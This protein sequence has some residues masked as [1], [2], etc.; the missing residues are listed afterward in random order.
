MAL[1]NIKTTVLEDSARG[2]AVLVGVALKGNREQLS[3]AE[4]SIDELEGLLETA[5]GTVV[6]KVIQNIESRNASTLIGSGKV[7]EISELCKNHEVKLVVFD[8]E[9]T[10]VQIRNLEDG[11][12]EDVMVIDRTMLILDIFALHATTAEGKLQVEMA[13]L[14]YSSP[15]LIGKGAQLSR[16][17]GGIGTRGPGESQLETDRRYIKRREQLLREQLEKMA[18]TRATMRQSRE[19]S[20]LPRVSIVGYTNAGKS[21]LLNALTHAG[22][23]AEDKLF[24]TLDPTT[25]KY[26]LPDGETIL[27]TDTVGF[28]RKLPHQLVEAFKTTLDEALGADLLLL[29]LDASDPETAQKLSVTVQLL[30]EL[31]AGAHDMILVY[32]KIDK[33]EGRDILPQL[34]GVT[35]VFISAA[36]GE[37]LDDLIA[38]V[39]G[40]LSRKRR[41]AVFCIPNKELGMLDYLYKH[42]KVEN[43]EYGP[44][45]AFVTAVTDAQTYGKFKAYI[46]DT[47]G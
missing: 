28:I 13:Q 22:I 17:A 47:D 39:S 20:G 15:R 43:V 21:T 24:A 26:E 16:Q 10:P 31:G 35:T 8:D 40:W 33:L 38:Q 3:E 46:L 29:I 42:A 1:S 11:I 27:L 18:S 5:G 41:H 36:T 4:V 37:G 14:K 2:N 7:T 32:N 34:D 6:A 12:G 19:K 23:L 25:R 45:A 44:E 9:L 30:T